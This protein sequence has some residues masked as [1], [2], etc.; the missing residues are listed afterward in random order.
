MQFDKGVAIVESYDFHRP[1][2]TERLSDETLAS[3]VFLLKG[4]DAQASKMFR[5]L[6]DWQKKLPRPPWAP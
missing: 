3:Y 2:L 5:E 4:G 1:R 6:A